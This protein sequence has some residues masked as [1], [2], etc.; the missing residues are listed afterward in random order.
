MSLEK[1]PRARIGYLC[2]EFPALSHTFISREISVL[3]REGFDIRTAS[4][5]VPVNVEKMGP[6]DREYAARTYAIKGT[7]KPRI[8]AILAKYAIGRGRFFPSLAYAAKIAASSGPRSMK[9]ALGYFVEAVL[10]HEWAGREGISHIHVHFANPAATVAMIAVKL[11]G[12]EFSL[13]V[14]GPDEFYDV[15]AN[16]VREKIEAAA[17][18][19]CIGFFCRSQLMRLSSMDQWGKFH[20]VRCGIFKDE[21]PRRLP[22]NGP[23]RNIL[24]VGRLC[25][26]KGQAIL[27]EAA[28]ILRR[29]NRDF[30]IRLLGG[31]PDLEAIRSMI[32]A[33][34]LG[35]RVEAIGP[36]GHARVKEELAASDLFV[37]PSFAEG[38]PVALMEAMASG[39]PVISTRIAGIPELIEHGSEGMLAQPS[40]AEE[41]ARA[42]DSFITG[43]ADARALTDKAATK[44]STMFDAEANARALGELFL[45]GGRRP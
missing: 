33:K 45:A 11:G 20:I 10:L 22:P 4:V 34:G 8:A 36:V 42:I 38:I 28:D 21:F 31:G 29:E 26:S 5:N 30:R 35:G 19:R 32:D 41:L 14:H 12:L 37:L 6:G 1:R 44:V 13:S 23:A 9:K 2:S 15:T 24:C 3:E 17:F 40:N 16:N 25:P 27:I 7:P 43:V 39:V 18:V